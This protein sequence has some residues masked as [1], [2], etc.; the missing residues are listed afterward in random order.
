[1]SSSPKRLDILSRVL[2]PEEGE[3]PKVVTQGDTFGP[4]NKG[5]LLR[6]IASVGDIWWASGGK[7][8]AAEARVVG[9]AL[10]SWTFTEHEVTR[11]GST[12][13]NVVMDTDSTAAYANVFVTGHVMP[14]GD[15]AESCGG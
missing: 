2:M 1:M 5:D 9:V 7:G 12:Y 14:D 4:F 3:A 10:G 15:D 13:I 11:E 6:I 8:V